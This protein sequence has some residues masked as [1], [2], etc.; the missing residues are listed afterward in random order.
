MKKVP[1]S[2]G[3]FALVDDEDF[4]RVSHFK[5]HAVQTAPGVFYA[6]RSAR[7]GTKQK[8]ILMHR[9]L[10]DAASGID[11]DHENR[12]RLDNRRST[13]IRLAT[14]GQ[15]LAAKPTLDTWQGR[16]KTSPFRGVARDKRSGRWTAQISDDGKKR[17]LGIFDCQEDAARC[18]DT[19]AKSLFGTFA[20]LNFP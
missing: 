19:A 6:A 9:F 17:H 4:E 16:K 10:L 14:R 7:F 3:M 8:M 1:L 13:N 5:W 15:N 18:Y 11:V 2:R 20:T 12:N